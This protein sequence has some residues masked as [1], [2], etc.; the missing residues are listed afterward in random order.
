MGILDFYA[1]TAVVGKAIAEGVDAYK[2]SD[3]HAEIADTA[4]QKAQALLTQYLPGHNLKE[5]TKPQLVKLSKIIG[6][7]NIFAATMLFLGRKRR[8][9]CVLLIMIGT[10][11]EASRLL[12]AKPDSWKEDFSNMLAEAVLLKQIFT[13]K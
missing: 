13:R 9:M 1:R 3:N 6:A 12:A 5:L 11:S 7:V 4:Q 10:L 2:N 8:F